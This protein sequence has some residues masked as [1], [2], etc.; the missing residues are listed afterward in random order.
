MPFLGDLNL[1]NG[2]KN[3]ARN[4][5]SVA[6]LLFFWSLHFTGSS[7]SKR[8]KIKSNFLRLWIIY[9]YSAKCHRD[10]NFFLS[11]EY[12]I[13]DLHVTFPASAL[14][15]LLVMCGVC[16]EWWCFVNGQLLGEAW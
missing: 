1:F 9:I 3:P 8:D 15:G 14:K 2:G 16:I 7:R 11:A 12:R 6:V 10:V 13:K 4:L 5:L